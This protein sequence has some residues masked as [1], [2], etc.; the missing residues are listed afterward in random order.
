VLRGGSWGYRASKYFA[1]DFRFDGAQS[2]RSEDV[3]FR[4]ARAP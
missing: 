4:V 3:G 2:I 1:P